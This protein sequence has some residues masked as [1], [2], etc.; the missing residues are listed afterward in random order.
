[1]ID[2]DDA[3]RLSLRGSALADIVVRQDS[4]PPVGAPSLLARTTALSSYPTT[5]ACYFACQPLSLL[6]T[7]LEGMPAAIAPGDSTFFALNL[8]S[9]VPTPG[10]QVLTTFVGNRW[11]FRHDA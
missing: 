11:V 2:T 9:T 5:P 1:M 3:R 7:E 10:T 8:G 4:D 6:G